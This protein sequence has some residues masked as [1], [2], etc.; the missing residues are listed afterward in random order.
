MSA[1]ARE[2]FEDWQRE[3]Q[4]LPTW[5]GDKAASEIWRQ[6]AMNINN[7][8]PSK[9]LKADDLQGRKLKLR[10]ASCVMEEIGNDTKPVLYFDGKEK[11]LVLNKTKAG[12]L[13]SSYSP[14]TEG[15][16]GKEIAIYPTKVNF[17]GQMVDAI[18]VE[19]VL[20]VAEMNDE[21]PF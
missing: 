14:E 8:F 17:Q 21:I 6:Q 10:I 12:I 13:A 15:W 20:E 5:T 18:A 3:L 11:G 16:M 7:V 4:S 9:Y 19:P 2:Y 1:A